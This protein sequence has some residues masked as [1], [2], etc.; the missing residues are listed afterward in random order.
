MAEQQIPQD[1]E[2]I[3]QLSRKVRCQVD[4]HESPRKLAVSNR[5]FLPSLPPG[6]EDGKRSF[7]I[8]LCEFRFVLLFACRIGNVLHCY[9]LWISCEFPV[10]SLWV[11]FGVSQKEFF[12]APLNSNQFRWVAVNFVNFHFELT[13]SY[14]LLFAFARRFSTHL[15]SVW[16]IDWKRFQK[17]CC[18]KIPIN[19]R[20]IF[21]VVCV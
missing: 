18:L 11:A 19:N 6:R 1:P 13:G 9:F 12:A 17:I 5:V 21:F 16:A 10:S 4:S 14:E 2:Q 15:R 8:C 20:A 7:I 3:V